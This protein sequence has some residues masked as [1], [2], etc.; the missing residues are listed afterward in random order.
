MKMK[1]WKTIRTVFSLLLTL[2]ILASAGAASA[3]ADAPLTVRVGSVMAEPGE[4]VEIPVYISNASGLY[5]IQ[6]ALNYDSSK[7]EYLNNKENPGEAVGYTVGEMLN[8]MEAPSVA[9]VSEGTINFLYYDLTPL[10]GSGELV[11]FQFRVKDTMTG[12]TAVSIGEEKLVLG[13]INGAAFEHDLETG[14][15]AI[16]DFVLPASLTAIESQAF[17][18]V[19]ATII[20]VP[21]NVQSIAADAF[22]SAVTL[23]VK[24]DSDAQ[25]AAQAGNLHYIAVP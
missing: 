23:I 6:F 11:R 13:D 21:E 14:A 18:G 12:I 15:V 5:Q 24:A 19:K 3:W 22:D 17:A 25:S 8:G 20:Y 2:A 9:S 1:N 16:A 4:T 10:N 7:L